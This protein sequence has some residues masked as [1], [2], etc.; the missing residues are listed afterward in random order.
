MPDRPVLRTTG[1]GLPALLEAIQAQ[2]AAAEPKR[3]QAIVR[4]PVDRVFSIK[5]FGTVV[6]GTLW[7]GRLSVGDEVAIL[8]RGL[9][10]RVR[11]CRC[12]ARPW[13]TRKPASALP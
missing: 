13:S 7:S 1:Q 5:G 8:P 10:S 2:A 9:R 12:T 4:L 3:T 11:R 6:T